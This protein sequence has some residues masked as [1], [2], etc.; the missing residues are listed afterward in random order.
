MKKKLLFVVNVDW[1]FLSHRL[2]IAL[3]AIR[4][5]YEVHLAT[6]ITTKLP[7]LQEAGLHVHP[8][9]LDRKSSGLMS[10]LSS[11]RQLMRIFS[12][13]KPDIVH[14]VTIKPVLLGG[15]AAR[16]VGVPATV[17]AIPGLGFIFVA[18]GL[19]ASLRRI[20]VKGMYRF[21]LGHKNATVI[22]QNTHD[23]SVLT[24]A[25]HLSAE[26][27]TLIRGSGVDLT[28]YVPQT[29]QQDAPVVMLAARLLADK[30]IYEFIEATRRIKQGSHGGVNA[31]F[32][33]VGD[34][35]PGNPTSLTNEQL[36]TWR[37]EG[38]IEL[39]GYRSDM[40]AV[41]P[42]ASIVVL[43]SYTEGL[44]KV[45]IEAA[46]CGRAVVASD[47]PGCR[48]AVEDGVSGILVPVK[49]AAALADAIASLLTSPAKRDAMG[50]AGRKLAEQVFDV[51]Q[52]VA[53]HLTIYKALLNK[54]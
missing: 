48:D 52:V 34:I 33:L 18:E 9:T 53:K 6:S 41:L 38:L 5:G 43:P 27:T 14:L 22:F 8:F 23:L 37:D 29:I 45:L 19:K 15:I 39:W 35:D 24:R 11:L 30:G 12:A 21:A 44:P 36:E 3:E 2:P 28:R 20:L 47:I 7:E 46:A 49:N 13:V 51:N 4:Q 42:L 26:K 31:R 17:A 54:S 16:L 1:F 10:A 25:A 50:Q 40:Y 32:V